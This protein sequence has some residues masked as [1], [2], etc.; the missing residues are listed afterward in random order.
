MAVELVLISFISAICL[1]RK[2]SVA[3][4]RLWSRVKSLPAGRPP[5]EKILVTVQE[6]TGQIKSLK[7]R[8][9]DLYIEKISNY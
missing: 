8:R 5:R 1:V 7:T 4:L 6:N 3:S 9:L 2:L